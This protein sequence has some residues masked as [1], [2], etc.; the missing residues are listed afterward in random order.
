MTAFDT[1]PSPLLRGYTLLPSSLSGRH[2][3]TSQHLPPLVCVRRQHR[4]GRAADPPADDKGP[5]AVAV[6]IRV[7]KMAL[8]CL[9]L[10]PSPS[11]LLD[12]MDVPQQ[13]SQSQ[14]TSI[15]AYAPTAV[16]SL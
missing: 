5:P 14:A 8:A 13:L 16:A 2:R 15:S 7:K 4:A 9:P 1:S 11:M 10:H 3:Y 12:L 6:P